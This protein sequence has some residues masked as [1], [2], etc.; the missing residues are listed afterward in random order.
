MAFGVKPEDLSLDDWAELFQQWVYVKKLEND[1][2][3]G[4]KSKLL[5]KAENEL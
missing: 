5:D 2:S 4:I 3:K 1:M